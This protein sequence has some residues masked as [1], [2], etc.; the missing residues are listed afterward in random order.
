MALQPGTRLGPYEITAP[1]GEGGMGEVYQATDTNLARQVAIKVLPASVASDPERL[2]RFDREAKTLAAL[3]HPNIAQIHGLEKSAGTIALVMELVEGPTLAD[4]IAQG[5]IPVDEALPIAKQ[6]AEALEAAHEQGIIHRDLKPANV[7][8]RPDGT[9]KVLD[10]GLAKALEP[11]GAM[12]PE[13]SQ[14]PTITTPA[15]TQ[16]GMILGTA[17]YMSPEQAKGR[18]VDK[19][20]DVWAFGAVFY[21]M[22]TGT[23]AFDAEDVSETLAAVLRA[24]VNWTPLPKEL[25]PALRTFLVRC[26]QKDPK[27]RVHDIADVRLALE[28]AFETG[29]APMTTAIVAPQPVWLRVLPVVAALVVGLFTAGFAVW[30]VTRPGT[31]DVARFDV[32]P[33]D[34][35]T[36]PAF[37]PSVAVSPDGKSVAYLIGG[38]AAAGA[39]ELHL[40]SLSQLGST[41]L[42]ADAGIGN[43]F[44]SPDSSQI[45]FYEIRPGTNVLKRVSI[46]GGPTSTIT[47]IPDLLRGASW[48]VDGT[49]IFAASDRTTGLWRVPAAGGEPELLTTPNEADGERDHFW[50]EILPGGNAVLFT[51]VGASEEESQIV[52]VTLATGERQVLVRGGT[53]PRY[54]STGHLLYGRAGSLWAVRFDV[55]RLETLGDP[56]PVQEGVITKGLLG[57]TEVSLSANGT[58]LYAAGAP[59]AGIGTFV[60][61]DRD[62]REEP[63]AADPADYREFTLSPDGTRVAVRITGDQPAVWIYDLVRD[64]STRLTFES[65]AVG[66][67]FPT[68]TPDGTRV[69]FGPPLSWKRADGIG[70]VE[71]LDDAAQRVPQAFSPDGT[72]LVFQDRGIAEGGG[73]VGVLTLEGDR[74][75]T[76]V[77]DGE[78][79]ERNPALSPDGRWVAYNSD[80][81][82]QHQVYV[83]PFPDVDGGKWQIST[84][85]GEW[86]VWNPAGNE[87][88]YR[89]RTGVMALAFEPEPT[90]TPGALTQ[91]FDRAILGGQAMAVSP[92]GQRFLLQVIATENAD[93]EATQTQ[94]IV[95][96]NWH[97]E[98]KRLVPVD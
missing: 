7:K 48:G 8:V 13:M 93:G 11:T 84:D 23:R 22:L 9:V 4:R 49:I 18:T 58:L 66:A 3:N 17:A 30:A 52:V 5:A 35:L 92:D 69:A 12:S 88:F 42:V 78:F 86:P 55:D 16:A 1:I 6:I 45:G 57:A 82:G 97:Q 26:L 28:G 65:D 94:L 75:A 46:Q 33:D 19:R 21:E 60:W 51:V 80:E 91:L 63:V 70:A 34:S 43:L 31:P 76:L 62:G 50:P 71:G 64:T 73:G 2:A 95:V 98:L 36:V 67:G 53:F 25:S 79:Q 24:E 38:S 83:Q 77:I 96:Q 61:V 29:G 89:S 59:R 56:I 15:M 47:E 20:S 10:F 68:W 41:I 90:F 87:L 54:S 37:S 27:Q 44:F 85:G 74:T 32:T 81:T 39:E 14:A 72:T 40:R